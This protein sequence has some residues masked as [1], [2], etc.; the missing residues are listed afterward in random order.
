ML[1]RSSKLNMRVILNQHQKFF[2]FKEKTASVLPGVSPV[3]QQD[4]VA[5]AGIGVAAV[6]G[7][8]RRQQQQWPSVQR[9]SDQP[10][11][12]PDLGLLPQQVKHNQEEPLAAE[13]SHMILTWSS[14]STLQVRRRPGHVCGPT[15]GL[16]ADADAG[17]G[18]RSPQVQRS[19]WGS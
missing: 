5:L 13:I 2:L 1:N 3:L 14:A 7:W 15:R 6:P 12:G 17:A 9:H 16:G 4:H 11:L 19:E 18:G 10:L 8:C